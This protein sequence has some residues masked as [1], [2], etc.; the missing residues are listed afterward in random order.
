MNED[1]TFSS[2][3]SRLK[4]KQKQNLYKPPHWKPKGINKNSNRSY[5]NEG[6]NH[7]FT[8][9]QQSNQFIDVYT[10]D[11]QAMHQRCLQNGM[12]LP[13]KYKI[14][15]PKTTALHAK[16]KQGTL[17]C[18][19][20]DDSSNDSNNEDNLGDI[21]IPDGMIVRPPSK[22]LPFF[23]LGKNTSL[24]AF[25]RN[26]RQT[27]RSLQQQIDSSFQSLGTKSDN[28]N[29]ANGEAGSIEEVTQK[30][31][32]LSTSA[33]SIVIPTLDPTVMKFA[34]A[35]D[36][37]ADEPNGF[38]CVASSSESV[39]QK[40]RD[41]T[42]KQA[43]NVSQDEKAT[44]HGDFVVSLPKELLWNFLQAKKKYDT[45]SKNKEKYTPPQW[46]KQILPL[47]QVQDDILSRLANQGI[48][49]KMDNDKIAT[50]CD[51]TTTKITFGHHLQSLLHLIMQNPKND[52][53][54]KRNGSSN[55][56]TKTGRSNHKK[57]Y[58]HTSK[59][60][61]DDSQTPSTSSGDDYMLIYGYDDSTDQESSMELNIPGGKRFLGE[62]CVEA[63]V[64]ET[65]EE[66]SL[67]WD[68]EWIT[69]VHQNMKN[70]SEKINRY[71]MLHPPKH[72]MEALE[73][74]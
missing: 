70:P 54:K 17:R 10:S 41:W 62:T 38:A 2:N 58:N 5:S 30:I 29:A 53:N 68:E 3:S 66:T 32:A 14:H 60:G 18:V 12:R 56:N 59:G 40:V 51:P 20:G 49:A 65:K 73:M 8:K 4:E 67:T 37:L 16:L 42:R 57:F 11:F 50:E 48:V 9:K 22:G 23:F 46:A 33:P 34:C 45:L 64:R 55:K 31:A 36:L 35:A 25:N 27:E 28:G 26:P 69:K 52:N 1:K 24:A 44:D 61:N 47:Q 63:A 74:E 13:I 39:I 19:D 71:Y 6:R 43:L 21:D 15:K 72:L 7:N